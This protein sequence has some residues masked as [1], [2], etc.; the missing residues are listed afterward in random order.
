MT[1][2]KDVKLKADVTEQPTTEYVTFWGKLKGDIEK[3]EDLTK[4]LAAI[5]KS[6]NDLSSKYIRK[7]DKLTAGNNITIEKNSE[8]KTII[9]GP[10]RTSELY[11]DGIGGFSSEGIIDEFVTRSFIADRVDEIYSDIEDTEFDLESQILE[12]NNKINEK[13]NELTAGDGI[14]LVDNVISVKMGSVPGNGKLTIKL[15][16]T[17]IVE[18]SANEKEDK[19]ANIVIPVLPNPESR[20]R[21]MILGLTD[22]DDPIYTFY[23]IPKELPEIVDASYEGAV[24]KVV[25]GKPEWIK[26]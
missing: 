8:D 3:Q 17:T 23:D 4:I 6:V 21:G 25:N 18:F 7:Q 19:E 15:N 1:E 11:N 10:T 2:I 24:L 22:S 26:E 13:Q 14:E 5:K 9:S 16:G 12:A 20:W